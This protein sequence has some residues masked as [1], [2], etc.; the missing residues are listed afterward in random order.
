M[1]KCVY[2]KA[3]IL[4]RNPFYALIA[5]FNRQMSGSKTEEID[6]GLFQGLGKLTLTRPL[7][8]KL[9]IRWF[10]DVSK[11]KESGFLNRTS[12]TPSD[13]RCDPAP[14]VM[15]SRGFSN[16]GEPMDLSNR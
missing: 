8:R 15:V 3:I 11:V 14:Q 7:R 5:E 6:P 9:R 12:L 13:F 10:F 4:I 16:P 1:K 2:E